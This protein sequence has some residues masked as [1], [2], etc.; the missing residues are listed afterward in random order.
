[1][2][3]YREPERVDSF[4]Q[5]ARTWGGRGLSILREVGRE[6]EIGN[7]QVSH[8]DCRRSA[9]RCVTDDHRLAKKGGAQSKCLGVSWHYLPQRVTT[10][11]V[12]NGSPKFTKICP[13]QRHSK[14]PSPSLCTIKNRVDNNN[15][16]PFV[17]S[18]TISGPLKLPLTTCAN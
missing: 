15:Q 6:G 13:W 8:G 12:R 1:M 2:S 4:A 10:P 7:S 18:N 14:V 5:L 17:H 9:T 11:L 16:V 3:E